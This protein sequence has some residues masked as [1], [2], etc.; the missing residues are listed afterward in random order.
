VRGEVERINRIIEQFLHYARPAAARPREVELAALV[1]DITALVR[2]RFDV[3]GVALQVSVAE[4]LDAV[5]DPDLLRQAL[6]NLL[7]NALGACPAGATTTVELR[8]ERGQALLTVRDTGPG[9]A[10]ADLPRIFNLYHTTKPAG[11]G[12]GLAIVDQVAAQHGGRV[13]VESELGRGTTFILEFPPGSAG[14][15]AA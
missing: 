4:R 15:G 13:Q 9:I 8:A 10:A 6:H 12:V 14:K 3:K 5:V 2:G 7:D 1:R 11:T